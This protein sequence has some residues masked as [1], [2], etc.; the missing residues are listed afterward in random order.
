MEHTAFWLHLI[1]AWTVVFVLFEWVRRAGGGWP[2]VAAVYVVLVIVG[3]ALDRR[4][5]VGAGL[6]YFAVGMTG[7]LEGLMSVRD[8]AWE[9]A[10]VVIGGSLIVLSAGWSKVR[11][12]MVWM[13]PVLAKPNERAV[14]ETIA[15]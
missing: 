14:P 1:G 12:W 9:L 11:R 15:S 10:A 6:L 8:L 4:A 5:P 3:L 13:L 7:W 2:A